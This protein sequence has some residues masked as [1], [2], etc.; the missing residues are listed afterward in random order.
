[1][2][3]DNGAQPNA[4]TLDYD[5]ATPTLVFPITDFF[6]S[7]ID[8]GTDDCGAVTCDLK[9]NGCGSSYTQTDHSSAITMDGTSYAVTIKRN[10]QAGY[11]PVTV[12][13]QCKNSNSAGPQTSNFN[14]W[15]I[16]QYMDCSTALTAVAGSSITINSETN[17]TAMVLKYSTSATLS[18]I[19][20]W[21]TLFTSTGQTTGCP[22]T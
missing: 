22:V 21:E 4:Q 7:F 11:G 1:M 9:V 14:N 15:A 6:S 13:V 20:T 19:S 12:C 2:I 16:E 5:A 8:T 10:I 17:P 18:Y 3:V